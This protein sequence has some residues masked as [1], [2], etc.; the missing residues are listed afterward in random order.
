VH[1]LKALVDPRE[2]QDVG[3]EVVDVDLFSC[4]SRPIFGTVREVRA[5]PKAV[6][7]STRGPVGRAGTGGRVLIFLP[8]AATPDDHRDAPSAGGS[9]RAPGRITGGRC[10]CTRSCSPRA[11][12]V[13]IFERILPIEKGVW[14]CRIYAPAIRAFGCGHADDMLAPALLAPAPRSGRCRRGRT[15][16]RSPPAPLSRTDDRA[17]AGRHAAAEVQTLSK[18]R[19]LADLASAILGSTVNSRSGASPCSDGPRVFTD[20]ESAGAVVHQP[21]PCVARNS[22]C[23]GGLR[24]K[25]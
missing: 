7:P 22:R 24:E 15:P 10:R 25:A 11:R 1:E 8:G 2:R 20:R 14:A 21:L 9:T 17:D 4:T 3:D 18:G 12:E 6:C 23:T 5:H 13:D 19:V 16:P